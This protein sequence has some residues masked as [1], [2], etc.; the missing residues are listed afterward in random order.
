MQLC[1]YNTIINI[2][3]VTSSVAAD[4]MT[5]T[6]DQRIWHV[7]PHQ[8]AAFTRHRHRAAYSSTEHARETNNTQRLQQTSASSHSA[9]E[10]CSG[11]ALSPSSKLCP[12]YGNWTPCSTWFLGLTSGSAIY[13][14]LIRMPYRDT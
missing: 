4:H 13:A 3:D 10:H 14:Q 5:E 8:I 2:C 1:T 6:S 11:P 12:P 9:E 7:L